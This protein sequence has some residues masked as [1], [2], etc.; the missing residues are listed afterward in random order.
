MQTTTT[1]LI[2][3]Y[4]KARGIRSDRQLCAALGIGSGNAARYRNGR[5]M[6]EETAMKVCEALGID[7]GP[8]LAN[9]AADR[10]ISPRVAREWRRIAKTLGASAMGLTAMLI[11]LA[12]APLSAAYNYIC[13][14]CQIKDSLIR[15]HP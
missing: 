12:D 1:K 9:L 5:T 15:T 14:L 6:D 10:E 2:D 11:N 13:I 4:K 7:P 3:A 8:T